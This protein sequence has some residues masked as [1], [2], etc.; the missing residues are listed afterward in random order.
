MKINVCDVCNLQDKKIVRSK[1]RLSIKDRQGRRLAIDACEAHK[2]FFK[3]LTYDQADAKMDAL[4][5]I[6]QTKV[7]VAV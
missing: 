2:G 3:G 5:G 7:A 4:Y 6:P 1:W